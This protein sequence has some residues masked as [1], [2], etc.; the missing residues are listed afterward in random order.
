MKGS[1]ASSAFKNG[2]CSLD[3]KVRCECRFAGEAE[4]AGP[5]EAVVSPEARRNIYSVSYLINHLGIVPD[6]QNLVLRGPDGVVGTIEPANGLFF[7]AP[8]LR[9]TPRAVAPAAP[10]EACSASRPFGTRLAATDP[11]RAR[12]CAPAPGA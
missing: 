9:G 4:C 1:S 10:R 8:E 7:V 12:L 2:S 3:T 11:E 5:L 6:F